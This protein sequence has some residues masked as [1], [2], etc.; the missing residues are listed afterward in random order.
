MLILPML[1][2]SFLSEGF[3]PGFSRPTQKA[4]DRQ[5]IS[6]HSA[7]MIKLINLKF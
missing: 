5:K 3:S 2:A 4:H 6:H 1:L 7:K